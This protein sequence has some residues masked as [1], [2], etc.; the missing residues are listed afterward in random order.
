MVREVRAIARFSF[1]RYAPGSHTRESL[2]LTHSAG[3]KGVTGTGGGMYA[4]PH[5]ASKAYNEF[6]KRLKVWL[7]EGR[8]V[9]YREEGEGFDVVAHVVVMP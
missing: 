5:G 9:D 6:Q 1:P 3:D 2:P 8:A 4:R 7:K